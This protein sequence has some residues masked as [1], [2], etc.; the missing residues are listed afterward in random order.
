MPNSRMR[1]LFVGVDNSCRSQIA[2]ALA[3][4]FFAERLEAHSAGSRPSGSVHPKAVLA[5]RSMGYDLTR[6]RSKALGD[7]PDVEWDWAISMG[8]GD[9]CPGVR[10]RQRLDWQIPDPRH[11]PLEDVEEVRDLIRVRIEELASSVLA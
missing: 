5:L 7:L 10:A 2:E 6:H 1:V 9:E 3:R 11:L 4:L 8:C